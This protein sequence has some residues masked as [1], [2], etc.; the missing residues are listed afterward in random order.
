MQAVPFFWYCKCR[1]NCIHLKTLAASPRYDVS[2]ESLT[3]IHDPGCTLTD[4]GLPHAPF[5]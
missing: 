3:G 1:P 5:L 2:E 4:R